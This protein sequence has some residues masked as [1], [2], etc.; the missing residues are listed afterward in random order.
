VIRIRAGYAGG[1]TDNPGYY[2][3]GDHSETVQI[4]FDPTVVTYAELLEVFWDS[5]SP[6]IPAGSRQYMSIIFFHNEDQHKIALAS[7]QQREDSQG[8][9]ILTE[10][11]S[12]VTFYQAED[13]HQKF[14]LQGEQNLFSEFKAMYPDINQLVRS[15]AAARVNGYVGGHGNLE[16]LMGQI[17]ALG[18]TQAGKEKLLE[19]GRSSLY[20][21]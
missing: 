4:E 2:T 16:T 17:N 1:T 6:T 12:Y 15:T 18:L 3:L 9:K 21:N 14:Y 7:K 19:I 13:Y 11:V 20:G 8:Y 5:H 10:V